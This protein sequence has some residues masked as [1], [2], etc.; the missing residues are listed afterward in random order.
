MTSRDGTDSHSDLTENS[1]S[2]SL[3]FAVFLLEPEPPPVP[4]RHP[5]AH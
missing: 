4:R 2:S 5:G 3:K 1:G